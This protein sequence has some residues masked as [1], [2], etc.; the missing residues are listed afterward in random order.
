MGLAGFFLSVLFSLLFVL[1]M[2]ETVHYLVFGGYLG[3]EFRLKHLGQLSG[4]VPALDHGDT[5]RYRSA[6]GIFYIWERN[7]P[8][9]KYI[10][11]MQDEPE[12][13]GDS[14]SGQVLRFS[15]LHYLIENKFREALVN[16]RTFQSW[17][18][19]VEPLD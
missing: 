7:H 13:D 16:E 6:G 18:D 12:I 9:C 3:E 11:K 14:A 17:E 15:R 10:I 19:I 1:V 5:L 4:E 2:I 8:L